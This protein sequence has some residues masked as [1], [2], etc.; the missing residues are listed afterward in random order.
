MHKKVECDF[1]R[2]NRYSKNALC[3]NILAME[4]FWPY[5][6]CNNLTLSRLYLDLKSRYMILTLVTYWGDYSEKTPRKQIKISQILALIR[7]PGFE[8]RDRVLTTP[9]S[10]TYH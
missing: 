10:L 5:Y 8:H 2:V 7:G 1:V 4:F 9:P 6:Q 3:L